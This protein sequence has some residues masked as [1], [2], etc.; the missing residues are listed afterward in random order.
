MQL[1]RPDNESQHFGGVV[2]AVV[3][4]V[5]DKR[6]RITVPAIDT[7]RFIGVFVLCAAAKLIASQL[8][9]AVLRGLFSDH[10]DKCWDDS[11]SMAFEPGSNYPKGECLEIFCGEDFALITQTYVDDVMF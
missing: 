10:P 2:C 4:A 9:F 6:G 3:C 5:R 7:S 8:N 1:A 11:R